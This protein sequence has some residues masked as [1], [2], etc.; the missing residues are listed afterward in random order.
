MQFQLIG[1]GLSSARSF[2]L[3]TIARLKN[4]FTADEFSLKQTSCS[5]ISAPLESIGHLEL[6][7]RSS[8]S[9]VFFLRIANAS[10]FIYA[11]SNNS[12][13]DGSHRIRLR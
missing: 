5:L 3:A 1:D 13:N 6:A 4:R 8:F 11:N 12:T 7:E 2:L 9:C 10:R